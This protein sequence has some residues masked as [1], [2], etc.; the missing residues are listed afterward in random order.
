MKKGNKISHF[1]Q[2]C[3]EQL[4][5]DFTE[6]RL[7]D[8]CGCFSHQFGETK[9]NLFLCCIFHRAVT[10]EHLMYVKEDLIIPQVL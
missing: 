4:R 9:F 10:T 5:K 8:D 1:L 7:V 3:V 2:K 6:F